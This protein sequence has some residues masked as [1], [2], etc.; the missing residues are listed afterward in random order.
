MHAIFGLQES[1][2]LTF[3]RQLLPKLYKK[4]AYSVYRI[5]RDDSYSENRQNFGGITETSWKESITVTFFFD[6]DEILL[7][8][9]I[10][11]RHHDGDGRQHSGKYHNIEGDPDELWPGSVC[12]AIF[13][14]IYE[15]E[16]V[17]GSEY[18]G[19]V[20]TQKCTWFGKLK[21]DVK[22]GTVK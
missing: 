16:R 10:R 21:A 17:N 8:H 13:H 3:K 9:T 12:D 20:T 19:P 5:V 14:D 11:H 7:F 4:K 22:N 1:D 6:K 2:R 15:T 18:F